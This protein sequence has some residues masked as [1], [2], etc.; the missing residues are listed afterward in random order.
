MPR[1]R[2]RR[3]DPLRHAAARG[4]QPAGH[5]RGRRPRHLRLQVPRG[6]PGP[7]GAGRRGDRRRAGPPASGC[8]PR[9]WWRSTSTP[10]SPATRPTRRS[11][12]CSTPAPGSTSGSTSCPARSGTTASCRR[13]RRRRRREGALA[14]RVHRQRRPLLA[15]PQPA[16]L[17]PRPL[18]DRPRRLRSTSTTRWSGG[19]CR[20]R[21]PPTV[22]RPAL[23]PRRPRAAR[24][25]A[26]GCRGVDE[27]IR[28]LLSTSRSSPRCWPR[29]PTSGS[30]R[31][32]APRPRTPYGPRTSRSS[33][34]ASA[35]ASGCRRW[36]RDDAAGSPTS[37]SCSA[38][39]RAWT[40]RSSSTSGVVLY[41]QA[42][43]FLDAAWHVDR[44]RLAALDP[45]STS[46]RSATRCGSSRASA[47]ATSAGERPRSRRSASASASSRRRAAPSSSPARSTAA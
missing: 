14:G 18:G 31:C 45:G 22:R 17:A 46:T 26:A 12:T 47:P 6:R 5:R 24:L 16:G 11:R 20:R 28:A 21:A 34:H 4:R 15:Q 3:R 2:D 23:E 19:R 8:G 39:C 29:C 30:S 38:A 35:P 9:G 27:E 32:P 37:T 7:A 41:C 33:P 25:R 42:T 13:R 36:R 40:A 1:D 10:R 43:D 44:D